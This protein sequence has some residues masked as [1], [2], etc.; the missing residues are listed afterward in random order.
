MEDG[1]DVAAPLLEPRNTRQDSASSDSLAPNDGSGGGGAGSTARGAEQAVV[2]AR[3]IAL[4][5]YLSL[6]ANVGLLAV[7][8]AAYFIR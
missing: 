7:K 3:K 8:T 1:K 4:A 5:I 2:L 6:A